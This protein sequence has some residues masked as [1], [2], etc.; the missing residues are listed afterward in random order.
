MEVLQKVHEQEIADD[1]IEWLRA[2]IM[3]HAEHGAREG[4]AHVAEAEAEPPMPPSPQIP[5]T[6]IF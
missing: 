6:L 1:L 3:F 2:R 5:Y 4:G